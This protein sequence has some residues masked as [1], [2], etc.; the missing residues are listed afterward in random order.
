[1]YNFIYW[2]IYGWFMK[3]EKGETL[4]RFNGN[5]ITG[6][7]LAIH[8]GFIIVVAR[9]VHFKT[10]HY[11]SWVLLDVL[12]LKIICLL[13]M[14]VP[15]FYYNKKRVEQL[16]EHYHNEYLSFNILNTIKFIL[17][18]ILPLLIIIKLSSK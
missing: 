10:M 12:P 14:A 2:V 6:L 4:S 17:I 8:L 3:K 13:T 16:K 1:M 7:T 11:H 15:F 5:L 18:M 9:A